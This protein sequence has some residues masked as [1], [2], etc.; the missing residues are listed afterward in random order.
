MDKKQKK[1]LKRSDKKKKAKAVALESQNK[2]KK[3]LNMFERLPESCSACALPFP[4]TREAH[5]TWRVTV[6]TH[7][8][9]V[10]LFCPSC[11]EKAK[12][13]VENNNEI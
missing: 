3:Q 9:Q 11:Q 1:R 4:R 12:K 7:A 5:M 2:M 8:Q 10:R 6:R 13:L